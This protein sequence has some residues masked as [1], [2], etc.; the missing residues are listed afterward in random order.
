LELMP[1]KLPHYILPL[2]PPVA[3]V[4]A[5]AVLSARARQLLPWTQAATVIWALIGSALAAGLGAIPILVTD[6]M[7]LGATLAAVGVAACIFTAARAA[8]AARWR[9]AIPATVA[10]SVILSVALLGTL[11]P[12]LD[13][14]WLSRTAL[15][16]VD[17]HRRSAATTLA[18]A[19]YHEPSLVFL[20]RGSVELVDPEGLAAFIER[21]PGGLALITAEERARFDAAAAAR[22]LGAQVLWSGDGIHY[23]KGRRTRL[24]LLAAK[25]DDAAAADHQ[26][27][28]A[29]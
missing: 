12:R 3:L 28:L 26:A 29:R 25:G 27:L 24:L 23:S 13:P 21:H 11:L 2:L 17:A 1:T 4:C 7:Q 18:A 8:W 20:A 15:A 14:L 6:S 19:G 5:R 10:A 9:V 16:A 22:G